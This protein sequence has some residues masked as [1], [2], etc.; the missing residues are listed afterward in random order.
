MRDLI[1]AAKFE[2][3]QRVRNRT[4]IELAVIRVRV[5]DA[6]LD[7][8]MRNF[9]SAVKRGELPD[10]RKVADEAFEWAES[11]LQELLSGE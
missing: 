1:E 11:R 9:D 6:A 4:Q 3:A 5:N 2:T 10:P 8:A 7:V